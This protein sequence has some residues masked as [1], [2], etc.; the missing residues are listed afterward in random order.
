MTKYSLRT[1]LNHIYDSGLCIYGTS[2]QGGLQDYTVQQV[3]NH[4]KAVK[5]L[6]EPEAETP[7]AVAVGKRVTLYEYDEMYVMVLK[8]EPATRFTIS[9]KN[10]ISAQ[11]LHTLGDFLNNGHRNAIHRAFMD[12]C[13]RLAATS[14]I[15][16]GGIADYA[17][18]HYGPRKPMSDVMDELTNTGSDEDRLAI[19]KR[20]IEEYSNEG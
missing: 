14:R 1:L 20:T 15:A 18:T 11:E 16:V 19:M 6:P 17:N 3:L 10:S 9:P 8:G 2:P 4:I 7:P 13:V 5:P 12:Y